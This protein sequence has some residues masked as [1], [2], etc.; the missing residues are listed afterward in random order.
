MEQI[1]V[2]SF[3]LDENISGEFQEYYYSCYREEGL[4]KYDIDA[5]TEKAQLSLS[6]FDRLP[7]VYLT[8]AIFYP[9]GVM[10]YFFTSVLTKLVWFW[11]LLW[12]TKIRTSAGRVISLHAVDEC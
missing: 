5:Q 1:A 12:G 9:P 3:E 4:V 10:S 8:P 7:P 11:N 6:F 2:D